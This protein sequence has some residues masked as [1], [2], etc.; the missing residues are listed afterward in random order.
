MKA[1]LV[2]D[3]LKDFIDLD[4]ALTTGSAGVNIINFIREKIQEFK[5]NDYPIVYICDSHKADDKEFDMFPPTA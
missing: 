2:I 1:L 5:I 4:G 3:M